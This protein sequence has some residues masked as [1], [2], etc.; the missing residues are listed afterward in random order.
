MLIPTGYKVLAGAALAALCAFGIW[1]YGEMRYADG[2]QF[3][4]SVNDALALTKSEDERHLEANV[5]TDKDDRYD[6][7]IEARDRAIDAAAAAHTELGR[8]RNDLARYQR[9]ASQSTGTQCRVDEA[10]ALAESLASCAERH[11]AVARDAE[12]DAEQVIGLQQYIETIAPICIRG[13]TPLPN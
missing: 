6:E 1:S 5:T 9:G 12:L 3:E 13:V 8:L 10:A 4:K 2:Q 11:Q 7:Y